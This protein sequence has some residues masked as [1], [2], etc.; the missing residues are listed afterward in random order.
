MNC[1]PSLPPPKKPRMSYSWT[2]DD[3][4]SLLDLVYQNRVGLFA[5]NGSCNSES[6][7]SSSKGVEPIMKNKEQRIWED[8]SM[9]LSKTVSTKRSSKACRIK[10]K[11][12]EYVFKKGMDRT[13]F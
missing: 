6:T 1:D 3:I 9:N 8:I 12:L 4:D 10:Y 13:A 5:G 11:Q 2:E 7:G